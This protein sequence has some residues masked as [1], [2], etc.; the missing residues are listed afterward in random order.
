VAAIDHFSTATEMRR[1]LRAREV[2]AVELVEMHIARIEATD[3]PLNAIPIRTPERALDAARRADAAIARGDEAPL[4]GLP[5]TLK[6]STQTGG[7]PQTAGIEALRGYQPAADG[8]IA[9]SVFEAGACLLGKTNIPVALADWQAENPIYGRTIPG[10]SSGRR[11]AARVAAPP[12]WQP[13]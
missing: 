1:A 11:A 7:L 3:A 6:E 12:R 8:P 2:S 13:V 9:T 5:M 10:T 4:L